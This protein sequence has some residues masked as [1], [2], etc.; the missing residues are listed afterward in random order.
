M[1]PSSA[2]PMLSDADESFRDVLISH[3]Q[4]SDAA[5]EEI[6]EAM[7]AYQTDFAQA[8]SRLGLI[9]NADIAASRA[10]VKHTDKPVKLGYLIETAL[11]RCTPDRLLEPQHSGQ[12]RAAAKLAVA[13]GTDSPRCEQ[14]RTLRTEIL[15]L[16]DDDAAPLTLALLSPG[17]SEGRSLLAAELAIAFSQL[18]Q[19]SLLIDADLR[20]PSQHKLFGCE[21]RFGLAQALSS[22]DAPHLLGVE[23]LPFLSVLLAG[24]PTPNPLELLSGGRFER[25]MGDFRKVFEYVIIDSPPVAQF[26]DGLTIARVAQRVV[27]V[28]RSDHTTFGDM[29]ETLRRI[30]STRSR[31]F[32]AIVNR[33]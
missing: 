3:C 4:L 14:I 8:G 18:G 30:S 1:K 5:V 9:S 25:L 10:W 22:Q 6:Q 31:I 13:Y 19:Y 15:L 11:S 12:A 2:S 23:N 28:S 29:K 7:R 32:G 24:A 20:H 16:R 27:V 33:F 21:N 17:A 26:A